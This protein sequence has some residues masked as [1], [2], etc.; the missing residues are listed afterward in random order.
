MELN[1][2]IM[3][4]DPI[5][6]Y[7]LI[8]YPLSG[9][10]ESEELDDEALKLLFDTTSN[11]NSEM[12]FLQPPHKR[13]REDLTQRIAQFK[14]ATSPLAQAKKYRKLKKCGE[15]LVQT[16]HYYQRLN[17]Q[18]AQEEVE[19]EWEEL[20]ID[21]IAWEKK[22][23][24][25]HPDSE[26]ETHSRVKISKQFK[27]IINDLTLRK[28][29][30]RQLQ[31][32]FGIFM[33][34]RLDPSIEPK[35][36]KR[37]TESSSIFEQTVTL[38]VN[39][40]FITIPKKFLLRCGSSYFKSLFENNLVSDSSNLEPLE[41]NLDKKTFRLLDKWLRYPSNKVF[42]G[43]EFSEI[44]EF[45]NATCQF[46]IPTLVKDCDLALASCV[47]DENVLYLLEETYQFLKKSKKCGINFPLPKLEEK[48][49]IC[50]G[51]SEFYIKPLSPSPNVNW[52]LGAETGIHIT[53][54]EIIPFIDNISIFKE[55]ESIHLDIA[56]LEL[57]LERTLTLLSCF[58][59]TEVI[60]ILFKY[61]FS[62]IYQSTIDW[63]FLTSFKKLKKIVVESD[64]FNNDYFFDCFKKEFPKKEEWQISFTIDDYFANEN[65]GLNAD[66]FIELKTLES[67]P[68]TFQ[69]W[70]VTIRPCVEDH[71]VQKLIE[72]Q[73][74]D[75]ESPRLDLTKMSK[76][77]L[78]TLGLLLTNMTKLEELNLNLN[79]PNLLS[80][81]ECLPKF[82][83]GLKKLTLPLSFFLSPAALRSL[84]GCFQAQCKDLLIVIDSGDIPIIRPRWIEDLRKCPAQITI[85]SWGGV[86]MIVGQNSFKIELEDS[87]HNTQ[88]GEDEDSRKHLTCFS[89]LLQ[90][91]S[92]L[93]ITLDMNVAPFCSQSLIYL[94][95]VF[96]YIRELRLGCYV[97]DPKALKGFYQLK[98][99]TL[100][101]P[102]FL[103]YSHLEDLQNYPID[104]LFDQLK[105]DTSNGEE[106]IRKVRV[107]MERLPNFQPLKYLTQEQRASLSDRDLLLLIPKK[108]HTVLDFS[109]MVQISSKTVLEISRN[110][111]KVPLRIKDCR[112]LHEETRRGQ[113]SLDDF[114]EL[115]LSAED[116][117][118]VKDPL[119]YSRTA[120]CT[121]QKATH[122]STYQQI[123]KCKKN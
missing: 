44:L 98:I 30:F 26:N 34:H 102:D 54:N 38:S 43:S 86:R 82:A 40:N 67:T 85:Q 22:I 69:D 77:S 79:N 84:N 88:L 75:F 8:L 66:H 47:D 53:I 29:H 23:L 95:Q 110:H 28:D 120:I 56:G 4:I 103:K 93:P 64:L 72:A 100:T 96:P 112:R 73:K 6:T 19:K 62:E 37:I 114:I 68:S 39:E 94:S 18:L 27:F 105:I 57:N 87:D 21:P 104:I 17:E 48:L 20:G 71:H 58:P 25:N 61:N 10:S 108:C 3:E 63:L 42:F 113:P 92:G 1:P 55:I 12:E 78:E 99:L 109:G 33:T 111:P 90:H 89:Q 122:R 52:L 51:H 106:F 97:F 83:H 118:Y 80:F 41:L 107:I 14:E 13:K 2:T 46:D 5:M 101:S 7:E 15:E 65:Q 91:F 116:Q 32:I 117:H 24:D 121:L 115:I 50:L 81:V 16:A 35:V 49:V 31:I 76:I 36:L 60:T 11:Q 123:A 70:P 59:N 119:S 45:L 74:F 9:K